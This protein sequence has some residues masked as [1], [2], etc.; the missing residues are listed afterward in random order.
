MASAPSAAGLR[1]RRRSSKEFGASEAGGAPSSWADRG[2]PDGDHGGSGG[3]TIALHGD[4]SHDN[5]V[6]ALS[7][8]P[9]VG[10]PDSPSSLRASARSGESLPPHEFTL[11]PQAGDFPDMVVDEIVQD[12]NE[13]PGLQALCDADVGADARMPFHAVAM[14][15]ALLESPP[16]MIRED[17]IQ[18]DSPSHS[19]SDSNASWSD[20]GRSQ[21]IVA[22]KVPPGMVLLN[23]PHVLCVFCLICLWV[24]LAVLAILANIYQYAF[25]EIFKQE[26]L[27]VEAAVEHARLRTCEALAPAVTVARALDLAFRRGNVVTL[28]DYSGLLRMLAPHFA[29]TTDLL[30]VELADPPGA[31]P[32]VLP[33]SAIVSPSRDGGVELRT[34]RGDCALVDG[35]RGCAMEPLG[36]NESN[37]YN[38]GAALTPA[39]NSA[40][41]VSYVWNGPTFVHYRP[42]EVIC[43]DLC[44][45][46]SF[47]LV[48]RVAGGPEGHD[49]VSPPPIVRVSV[50]VKALQEV[51]RLTQAHSRGYAVVCSSDGVVLAAADM[52]DAVHVDLQ[53]GTVTMVRVW[54]ID[55]S[56]APAAKADFIASAPKQEDIRE[57]GGRR[58]TAWSLECLRNS[59]SLK[60]V[61]DL[62]LVL[63]VPKDAFIDE[64]IGPLV[65]VAI[66]LTVA[67]FAIVFLLMLHACCRECTGVGP[68]ARQRRRNA[69]RMKIE[70]LRI[71]ATTAEDEKMSRLSQMSEPAFK[72]WMHRRSPSRKRTE[73][74]DGTEQSSPLALQDAS[75]LPLVAVS[76]KT[77][78]SED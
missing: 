38:A 43:D 52:E 75:P 78:G 8:H 33:G 58:I 2:G 54:E 64:L 3:D 44:W 70:T 46:P 31:V 62:R 42:H 5:G 23:Q 60:G 6:R 13:L 40:W 55:S 63:A 36:A 18:E 57:E 25:V 39:S 41:P 77:E 49:D 50:D 74:M 73:L 20:E 47:S 59:T 69:R 34:D 51:V 7:V 9:G 72:N 37:W 29:A 61:E 11:D 68:A 65:P 22:G 28:S 67:P 21:D 48:A 14:K 76:R 32:P 66:G 71:D 27:A 4:D 53:N 12:Y 56:W 19:D 24:L 26:E 15:R 16:T 35:R 10:D 17:M 1:S 45:L 30:E